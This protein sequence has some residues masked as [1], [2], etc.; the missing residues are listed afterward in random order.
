MNKRSFIKSLL[1]GCVAPS[2]F[3]PKEPVNWKRSAEQLWVPNPAWKTAPYECAFVFLDYEVKIID[4]TNPKYEVWEK[5]YRKQNT[6]MLFSRGK[7]GELHFHS[8]LEQCK[9]A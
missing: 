3:L 1:I 2:V 5:L 6:P 9:A 8:R 7:V 4:N